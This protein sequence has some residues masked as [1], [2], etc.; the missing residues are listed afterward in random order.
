MRNDSEVLNMIGD[1]HTLKGDVFNEMGESIEYIRIPPLRQTPSGFDP[2]T[3][4]NT[5][6]LPGLD[7]QIQQGAALPRDIHR[8]G[9]AYSRPFIPRRGINP[10]GFDKNRP[11][12]REIG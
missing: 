6:T 7:T 9:R 2:V 3:R 12:C 8:L 4:D 11:T 5:G 1:V 10:V